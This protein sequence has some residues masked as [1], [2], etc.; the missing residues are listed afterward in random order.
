M[1]QGVPDWHKFPPLQFPAQTNQQP[2]F[3]VLFTSQ[4]T[5]RCYAE[6]VCWVSFRHK[7]GSRKRVR[8]GLFPAQAMAKK[9]TDL[10]GCN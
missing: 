6:A 9:K 10:Q 2:F 1:V 8:N 4:Y 3:E 7:D 5:R